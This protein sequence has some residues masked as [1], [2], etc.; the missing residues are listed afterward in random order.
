MTDTLKKQVLRE[1]KTRTAKKAILNRLSTRENRDELVFLL[2]N[3]P[4]EKW[5]KK[6]LLLNWLLAAILLFLT[7]KILYRTAWLFM[8]TQSQGPFNPL[9]LLELIVPA[10][11]FYMLRK[12][13]GFQRQGYQF[14]AVLTVLALFRPENRGAPELY[15]YLVMLALTGLLYFGLFPKNEQLIAEDT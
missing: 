10:I 6:Y 14:L 2:N 12:C 4:L 11:N 7:W 1:L 3:L 9:L 13:L 8:A 15:M 5:R